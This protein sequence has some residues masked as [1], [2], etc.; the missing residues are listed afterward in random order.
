MPLLYQ[1]PAVIVLCV[2]SAPHASV[3]MSAEVAISNLCS[4]KTPMP[5]WK[6]ESTQKLI[7]LGWDQID[8]SSAEIFFRPY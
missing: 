3:G 6:L 4:A 7:V 8:I 5:G 2:A 1:A